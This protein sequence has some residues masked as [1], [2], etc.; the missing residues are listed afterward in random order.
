VL[1][2]AEKQI[3]ATKVFWAIMVGY[4]G[5]N[6]LPARAGELIR[7][8]YVGKENELPTSFALA[9]GIVE[10]LMDLIAL[11]VFGS[12]SLTFSG[13]VSLQLQ[14]ALKLMTVIAIISLG[15]ILSAPYVGKRAIGWI[16]ILPYIN[17]SVKGKVEGFLKQFLRGIEALH[18]PQRA[19]AFVLYTFIIWSMDGVGA[20]ILSHALH[21]SLTLNQSFLL[22]A[23]LGLSSAIPS[24]PGYVGVYQFVAVIVLQPFGVSNANA[25]A[26]IIFMQLTNLLLL[27]FW[28]GIG[29]SRTSTFLGKKRSGDS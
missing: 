16:S 5:N 7:A 6:I 20:V 25:L 21:I 9:T 29:I 18:H 2:S 22:L 4:L 27:I 14:G 24:T 28:G 23:A 11:V 10:R 26:F 12:I 17:P 8:M 19:V 15:G 13:I 3:P 1:L